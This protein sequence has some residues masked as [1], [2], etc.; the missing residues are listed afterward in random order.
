MDRDALGTGL[1]GLREMTDPAL[2]GCF[3]AKL[4]LSTPVVSTGDL[5]LAHAVSW[6]FL[7]FLAKKRPLS[8]PGALLF[9][10]CS[11]DPITH[12][13]KKAQA[14]ECTRRFF[15]FLCLIKFAQSIMGNLNEEGR[16]QRCR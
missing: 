2:A 10:K 3:L 9:Q 12:L 6:H 4:G 11:A 8:Q 14:R 15:L 5:Q 7:A 16:Q 1:A 13:P